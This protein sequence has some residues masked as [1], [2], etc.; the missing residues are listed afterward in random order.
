MADRRRLHLC[1]FRS[2]GHPRQ[3]RG[4]HGQCPL[5]AADRG[6]RRWGKVGLSFR[7]SGIGGEI[8]PCRHS[9]AALHSACWPFDGWDIPAGR[10]AIAEV[11][12]AWRSR[13]FANKGRT[14]DQHDAITIAA[15]LSRA[16][17]DGSLAAFLKP[18]LSPPER[19]L[20]KVEGWILGV[21]GLVRAG[22]GCDDS[23]KSP[24]CDPRVFRL[25]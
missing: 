24:T 16:D 7:C 9:L 10:S 18:D 1:R 4:A 11:Y 6:G 21:P 12:P 20:A 13:S 22:K 2:R 5:A 8:H 17:Q 14:C 19:T 3:R 25:C 23:A 15:W